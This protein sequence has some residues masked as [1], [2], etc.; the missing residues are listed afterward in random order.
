MKY[1]PL[2]SKV[3]LKILPIA[4]SDITIPDHLKSAMGTGKQQFFRVEA[5]GPSAV[6]EQHPLEVGQKVMISSHPS[7]LV[8]VDAVEQLCVCY[9]KDIAVICAQEDVLGQN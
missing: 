1:Q 2:G 8:G 9:N 5:L 3:L 4:S 6:D 7:L